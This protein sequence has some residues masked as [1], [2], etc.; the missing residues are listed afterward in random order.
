M[1]K[2]FRGSLDILVIFP[3]CLFFNLLKDTAEIR[4]IVKVVKQGHIIHLLLRISKH[5]LGL[6]DPV[7]TGEVNAIPSET[8]FLN[9]RMPTMHSRRTCAV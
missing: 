8:P 3:G 4:L 6:L 2:C 7:S 9:K 1:R 5:F